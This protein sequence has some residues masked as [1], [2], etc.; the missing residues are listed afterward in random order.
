[1][2]ARRAV[3]RVF[4]EERGPILAT[5]IHVLRDFQLA[6]D[7]LMDAMAAALDHWPAHGIPDSP[8]AWIT[9]TARNRALDRLRRARTRSDKADVVADLQRLAHA[10]SPPEP[11]EVAD[12][13]LRLIFTCCHPALALE[14]RVALTLRTLGGLSTVEIARAFLV[15]DATMAQ[16]L[17][18]ARRKITDAGIPY[19][20]PPADQLAERLD[21]VLAVLYLIFNEGYAASA[22]ESP[23]RADLCRE[24]IRLARLVAELVPQEPEATGLLALMMLQDAR[25]SARMDSSGAQILLEDQDRSLWDAEAI[26][27]GQ[28]LVRRTLAVGRVGPYQVQAAIAALHGE[29]MTPEATDWPQ[30]AALYA[31]LDAMSGSPVVSLNR[32]VAEGMAFGPARGLARIEAIYA[33]GTLEDYPHL[34]A[35]RADLLR[36]AGRFEEART[37]YRQAIELARTE[38]D[39]RVMERRLLEVSRG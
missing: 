9:R 28:A 29:A 19:Q 2:I 22:G 33:A 3:E 12:D 11:D 6:E 4:R 7:A 13:Q 31:L 37:Y 18:R 26:G 23:I 20:I 30:I 5:L 35:A 36:R 1:V 38:D 16:R 39:R 10:D 25:R 34:P 24:A 15:G 32:A 14:A 27:R 21:G 8:A 17:V